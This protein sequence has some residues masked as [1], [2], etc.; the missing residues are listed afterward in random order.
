MKMD[1]FEIAKMSILKYE[2]LPKRVH[3]NI[4]E[5]KEIQFSTFDDTYIL[6]LKEQI[7]LNARG[8]DWTQ[9]LKNRMENLHAFAGIQ[10]LEKCMYRERRVSFQNRCRVKESYSLG[11]IQMTFS[12]KYQ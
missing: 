5:L 7:E 9:R 12:H 4:E 6:F 3:D 8:A 11:I 1:D 10:L 2:E